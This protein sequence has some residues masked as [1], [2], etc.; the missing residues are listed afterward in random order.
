MLIISLIQ[1]YTN[2]KNNQNNFIFISIKNSDK[3]SFH[4]PYVFVNDMKKGV[5]KLSTSLTKLPRVLIGR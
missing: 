4:L 1:F 2:S 5:P 3:P